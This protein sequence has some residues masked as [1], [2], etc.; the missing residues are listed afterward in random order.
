MNIIKLISIILLSTILC[1]AQNAKVFGTVKASDTNSPI[2]GGNIILENTNDNSKIYGAATVEGG[3]YLITKIP[4]GKYRLTVNAMGYKPIIIE[5]ILLGEGDAKN[6]N[7][8]MD[9]DPYFEMQEKMEDF[10]LAG[11]DKELAESLKNEL[12]T[13]D[14][15]TYQRMLLDTYYNSL[16]I[17]NNSKREKEMNLD[18]L[19]LE[20]DA[21][22]LVA[23][24]EK[25]KDEDLLEQAR[26][27]LDKYY[28]LSDMLL[29]HQIQ[30]LRKQLDV[31]EKQYLDRR[32][33]RKGLVEEHLLKLLKD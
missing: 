18:L 5:G 31:I 28:S 19:Q 23:K 32:N 27:K 11:L 7:F 14:Q 30:Q 9:P 25:S 12:K 29:E 17:Q 2:L 15:T 26:S 1:H 16:I 33:D 4:T 10:Y 22:I 6:S 13:I 8:L 20:V 3:K 21:T 24:Y